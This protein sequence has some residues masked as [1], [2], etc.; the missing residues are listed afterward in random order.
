MTSLVTYSS[1]RIRRDRVEAGPVG[2]GVAK[3]YRHRQVLRDAEL[4]LHR[5]EVVAIVGE[6]GAGKTTLLRIC[7]GLLAPD[8]GVVR[9]AG[10]VGYCPQDPALVE[11]L[12]AREHLV[13][14]GCAACSER[15]QGAH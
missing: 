14:F 15:R 6:N 1:E 9:R 2:C 10:R 7:A 3:R 4:S 13:L 8:A 11:L 5:G 12:T